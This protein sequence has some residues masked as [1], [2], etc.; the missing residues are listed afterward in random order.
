MKAAQNNDGRRR[1]QNGKS[2]LRRS[3]VV[4]T[5]RFYLRRSR[6]GQCMIMLSTKWGRRIQHQ[7]GR[8]TKQQPGKQQLGQVPNCSLVPLPFWCQI[9]YRNLELHPLSLMKPTHSLTVFMLRLRL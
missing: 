3:G 8:E 9:L 2:Q 4:S 5:P 1:E 7:K 6:A